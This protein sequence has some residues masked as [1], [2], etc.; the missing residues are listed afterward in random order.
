MHHV[1]YLSL[2]LTVFTS[3]IFSR[4][5]C[6]LAEPD[7]S[8]LHDKSV[9]AILSLMQV[10]MRS[11]CLSGTSAEPQRIWWW[12]RLL[13]GFTLV[14]LLKSDQLILVLFGTHATHKPTQIVMAKLT[15]E[16]S[17]IYYKIN[18]R[19]LKCQRSEVWIHIWE[20]CIFPLSLACD[21]PNNKS[22]YSTS[23]PKI[24]YLSNYIER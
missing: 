15:V 7:C 21:K 10:S 19:K 8:Q 24:H 20:L 6:V 12:V 3:W 14:Y 13:L 5:L 17:N 2:L 1:T 23:K 22:P 18:F 16:F 4:I 9:S 11:S